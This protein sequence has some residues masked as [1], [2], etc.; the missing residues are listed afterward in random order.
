MEIEKKMTYTTFSY[1]I[2]FYFISE[3]TEHS[4][5]RWDISYQRYVNKCE[6]NELQMHLKKVLRNQRSYKSFKSRKHNR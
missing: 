1:N 6:I 4:Q 5:L 2:L 3:N